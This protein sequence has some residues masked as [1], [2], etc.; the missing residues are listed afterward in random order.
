MDTDRE[1]Q[2]GPGMRVQRLVEAAFLVLALFTRDAGFA[3]VTFALTS[4]QAI[5][6]RWAVVALVVARL[7]R[8]DGRHRVGDLYFD[9]RGSRGA[10]AISVLAQ[11]LGLALILAGYPLAGFLLLT[12]PTASFLIA[13]TLGFC[14]GCWFYVLGRDWLARRGLRRTFDGHTDI[15]VDAPQCARNQRQLPLAP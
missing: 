2:F 11:A 4:L 13:P 3:L 6:P 8:F 9:L 5:S 7:V 15:C 12:V 1:L 14:A 10:C